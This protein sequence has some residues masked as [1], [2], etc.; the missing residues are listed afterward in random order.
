MTRSERD[1][2][3]EGSIQGALCA[4][5]VWVVLHLTIDLAMRDPQARIEALETR[6]AE[7]EKNPDGD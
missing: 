7:L 6:V 5:I 2:L 4:V 1:A 3:I